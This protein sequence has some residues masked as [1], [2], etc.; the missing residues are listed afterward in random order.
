L[1]IGQGH[2]LQWLAS[3]QQKMLD[4]GPVG[5]FGMPGPAMEPDFKELGSRSRPGAL[6]GG[7]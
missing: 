7:W 1:E 4:V 3:P 6:P 5:S 2:L